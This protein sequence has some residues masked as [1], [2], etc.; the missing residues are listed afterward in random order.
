M[1]ATTADDDFDMPELTDEMIM[2]F[3]PL[4]ELAHTDLHMG[5]AVVKP[6]KTLPEPSID[7]VSIVSDAMIGAGYLAL[8]WLFVR[9]WAWALFS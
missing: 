1:M 5:A 8:T 6:L 9:V 3:R 4:T 2:E 7:W